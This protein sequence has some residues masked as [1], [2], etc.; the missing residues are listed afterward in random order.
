MQRLEVQ[1]IPLDCVTDEEF[2]PYGYIMGREKGEPKT[3]R[4][5]LQYWTKTAELGPDDDQQ[6]DCGLLVCHKDAR[7]VRYFERHPETSEN[8]VPVQG[9]CIF[10]MAPIDLAGEKPDV[11]RIKAFYLNGKLGVALPKGNWHW[12]PIPLGDCVKL[13]LVKK[14]K[15]FQRQDFAQLKDLGIEELVIRI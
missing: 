7:T 14:G 11:S 9:E 1:I 15:D 10:V 5:I 8:F 2:A 6:I 13:V 12:P 3:S 4:D